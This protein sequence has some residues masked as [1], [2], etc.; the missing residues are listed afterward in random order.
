M[1]RTTETI[2]ALDAA[3]KRIHDAAREGCMTDHQYRSAAQ[4]ASEDIAKS[5]Q[6]AWTI[7]CAARVI[8]YG[9]RDLNSIGGVKPYNLSDACIVML[10]SLDAYMSGDVQAVVRAAIA[11]EI[12]DAQ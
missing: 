1:T 10:E 4:Y 2:R 6:I 9:V 3:T 12:E 11:A 5:K 7:L 8:E